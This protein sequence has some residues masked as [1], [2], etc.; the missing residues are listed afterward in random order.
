MQALAL[1]H[2]TLAKSTVQLK[3]F[4]PDLQQQVQLCK[5][6]LQQ[7]AASNAAEDLA[8]DKQCATVTSLQQQAHDIR[9]KLPALA[10][11]KSNE[12]VVQHM[13]ELNL[14]GV[15]DNIEVQSSLVKVST[16]LLNAGPS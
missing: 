4:S 12:Q 14:R 13:A 1:T 15:I 16:P 11:A 3:P 10:L 6:R 9:L 7:I 2:N 5:Q 8:V